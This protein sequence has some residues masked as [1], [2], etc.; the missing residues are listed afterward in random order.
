MKK[1]LL[2]I[3]AVVVCAVALIVGSV[4]GTIAFLRDM[5]V[6]VNTFTYGDVGISM[7]ESY[8]GEDGK[9]DGTRTGGNRYLLMP[10]TSYIKDPVIH[11]E[12]DSQPMYL[13][14]RVDNGIA[15]LALK[16]SEITQEKQTIH[17]QLLSN[18]WKVYNDGTADYRTTINTPTNAGIDRISTATV[19][20]LTA[21]AAIDDVAPKFVDGLSGKVDVPTFTKFHLTG[22]SATGSAMG[23]YDH[24]ACTITI[25]AYAVQ[26]SGIP[27]VQDAASKFASEFASAK[28]AAAVLPDDSTEQE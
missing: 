7:D 17:Q 11:V 8:I 24:N 2:T 21:S 28:P 13:F 22:D 16:D 4:A 3:L 12:A 27:T 20:Y 14:L 26:A 23:I 18:G 25:T 6:V 19:Y 9:P 10:G 15:G 5:A 1:K